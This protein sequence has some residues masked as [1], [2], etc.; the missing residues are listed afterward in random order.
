[1]I[2][3]IRASA[4]DGALE[5][6]HRQYLVGDL[7]LPQELEHLLDRHVELGITRFAA[8]QCEKPHYHTKATEYQMLLKGAAKYVDLS[9]GREY[10]VEAGD[11]FVIRP[12]TP[13]M[14]KS[15]Q[16]TEILFFKYPGGNDK[17]LLPLTAEM[18]GWAEAWERRWDGER[19][20]NR[21][22][23]E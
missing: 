15:P 19:E 20:P 8:Y 23:K 5:R 14:Q 18:K 10:Q 3:I 17:V 1:M 7:Q 2:E 22:G 21:H 12:Q 4:I 9:L 13:Y 11:V 16:G 6:S